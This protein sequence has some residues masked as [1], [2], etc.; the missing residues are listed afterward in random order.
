MLDR[1]LGNPGRQQ[2]GHFV[3]EESAIDSDMTVSAFLKWNL[4]RLENSSVAEDSERDR[5]TRDF[6][7]SR[8]RLRVRGAR[9]VPKRNRARLVKACTFRFLG[10]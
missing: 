9:D 5:E 8:T 1:F 10:S 7:L 6:K 2:S 4:R 3:N